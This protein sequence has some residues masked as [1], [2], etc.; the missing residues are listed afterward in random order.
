M[1]T[2]QRICNKAWVRLRRARPERRFNPDLAMVE[3]EKGKG[4]ILRPHV[5]QGTSFD[6]EKFLCACE[7]ECGEKPDHEWSL[8]EVHDFILRVMGEDWALETK[9]GTIYGALAVILGHGGEEEY[10]EPCEVLQRLI[11]SRQ[12]QLASIDER[13]K[14]VTFYLYHGVAVCEECMN[15]MSRMNSEN[16]AAFS[17]RENLL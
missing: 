5:K 15:A 14:N 11:E 7:I 1:G 12:C 8:R 9:T 6:A 13:C 3:A 4:M 16:E 17:Q 2:Q 10:E